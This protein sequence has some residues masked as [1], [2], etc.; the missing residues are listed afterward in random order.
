MRRY[1]VVILGGGLGGLQCGYI[2]AKNGLSV[3]VVEK[4]A[5]LGGCIQSYYRFGCQFD[6][7][8]HYVGAL[9]EGEVLYKIFD[10]LNL[11]HL[12]WLKLDSDGFEEIILND[13]S[14]LLANGYDNY[15]DKLSSNFKSSAEDIFSY[16][17]FLKKVGDRI[18]DPV[19]NS[20]HKDSDRNFSPLF[21]QSAYQYLIDNLK[22]PELVDVVSG[23]SLKMELNRDTLPLYTFSQINS[24]FIQ[25]AWR[26]IG[27]GSQIA[28]SLCNDIRKMG[29]E[30]ITSARVARL[31]EK[32]GLVDYA[33][34]LPCSLSSGVNLDKS[35][36]NKS[37]NCGL[38]ERIYGKHFI[39]N[40]NPQSTLT[41]LSDSKL[42]RP[43]FIKRIRSLGQTVGAFTVNIALKPGVVE[44]KNRNIYYYRPGT[45][46]WDV[47]NDESLNGFLI[48]FYPSRRK[49]GIYNISDNQNVNDDA[50]CDIIDKYCD[51]LDILAPMQFDS[52]KKWI[53]TQVGRRGEDYKI[54]KEQKAS[55]CIEV[56]S[57]IIPN[58][59]ENIRGISTST[60]LTYQNY[61]DTIEGSAFGIRKDYNSIEKS[62]LTP[63]TPIPNLF[64]TGQN[65]NLHGILG[66]SITS[67]LT[68]SK[69]LPAQQIVSFLE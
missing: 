32:D 59:K 31:V 41:L 66:V 62:L 50:N 5:Q 64:F 56:A 33:E 46:V 17:N 26:L 10:Y 42:I 58:L 13:K 40:I 52:V 1:D 67:L 63:I 54:F 48:N 35:A 61:T 53:G 49:N 65:L 4:N 15:A 23:S 16:S 21:E 12:P 60:P 8:F 55:E 51:S 22:N 36:P 20:Y 9:G 7:G 25:S 45:S 2:L 38:G 37:D 57:K 43:I 11:M 3:C 44:Y 19:L 27:G 39:S 24:S 30:V 69:I 34:L 6:A 18:L 28:Q 14:F 47:S 29:G 68:C